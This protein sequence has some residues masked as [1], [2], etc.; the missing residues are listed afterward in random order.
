MNISVLGTLDCEELTRGPGEQVMPSVPG[1]ARWGAE[2]A[3]LGALVSRDGRTAEERRA[4][5][6]PV[7]S[8][9][10][11]GGEGRRGDRAVETPPEWHWKVS[12]SGTR[13]CP[14]GH[15]RRQEALADQ[16]PPRSRRGGGCE[17]A[18]RGP[19]SQPR[20]PPPC[21]SAPPGFQ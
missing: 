10:R 14:S 4:G 11:R 18:L 2:G 9:R 16:A 5:L 7:P 21:F 12:Q 3:G 1:G 19:P 20:T 8:T 17:R 15:L 13:L 6:T